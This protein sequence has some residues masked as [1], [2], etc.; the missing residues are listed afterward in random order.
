M[1]T[2]AIALAATVG[3]A[4]CAQL[5]VYTLGQD[6][7]EHAAGIPFHAAKP[8]LL[9]S[10]T[11]AK[12]KPVDVQLIYLP[13]LSRTYFARIQ[14]GLLGSS[15]TSLTF[16]N[17]M[18]TTVGQKSD[19]QLDELLTSFGGLETALATA[20]KLRAEADGLREEAGVDLAPL[21]Q[22]LTT[23]DRDLK[24]LVDAQA[25]LPVSRRLLSQTELQILEGAQAAIADGATKLADPNRGQA[26]A[27]GVLVALEAA[28][29]SWD[30]DVRK[31]PAGAGPETVD[32]HANLQALLTQLKAVIADLKPKPAER[33]SLT[34]YEIQITTAGT[35]LREV[36]MPPAAAGGS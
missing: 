24:R 6:G 11:G 5:Q 13:D 16:S 30:E 28:A 21:A 4:G 27:A 32:F 12:D 26:S 14:P 3:L 20:E 31:T 1:R 9:V 7:K 23:I 19:A 18:L 29:K 8:Y 17:G 22:R 33:P 25:N 15:E 36:P 2:L 34:L 35:V 10:R